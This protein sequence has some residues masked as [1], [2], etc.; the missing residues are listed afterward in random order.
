MHFNWLLL[1][2]RCEKGPFQQLLRTSP[3]LEQRLGAVSQKHKALRQTLQNFKDALPS[4][5]EEAEVAFLAKAE[6]GN[7]GKKPRRGGKETA[8]EGPSQ[9][10]KVT[11]DPDTANSWLVLSEDRKSV[12][13]EDPQ[14]KLPD[15]PERFDLSPS[16]LG[17]E[18]FVSGKYNWEVVVGEGRWW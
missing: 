18:E 3:E 13:W 14:Q 7:L 1:L 10:V 15:N 8:R 11:L 12:R 17:C 16:V 9:K 5:L 2:S 6:R 4:E